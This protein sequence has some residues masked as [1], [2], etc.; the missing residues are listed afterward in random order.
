[1]LQRQR[2]QARAQRAVRAHIA[3]LPRAQCAGVQRARMQAARV[4]ATASLTVALAVTKQ[5]C[6]RVQGDVARSTRKMESVL[7]P[8][9]PRPRTQILDR[10]R[11][12]CALHP[13]IVIMTQI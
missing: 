3:F 2:A 1:M 4:K 6:G 5:A 7:F 8:T 11:D 9:R 10:F 13:K 12:L